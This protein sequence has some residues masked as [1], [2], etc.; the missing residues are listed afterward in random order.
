MSIQ[1][2]KI[3]DKFV[4][5]KKILIDFSDRHFKTQFFGREAFFFLLVE[6]L[7]IFDTAELTWNIPYMCFDRLL[8]NTN[9]YSNVNYKCWKWLILY[10]LEADAC[11]ANA[12]ITNSEHLMVPFYTGS[13]KRTRYFF[14]FSWSSRR[15]ISGNCMKIK[16]NR[17]FFNK[18]SVLRS[19][20]ERYEIFE[21]IV[22]ECHTVKR[23]FPGQQI[24][25]FSRN[26]AR[27]NEQ[28]SIVFTLRIFLGTRSCGKMRGNREIGLFYTKRLVDRFARRNESAFPRRSIPVPVS[29]KHIRNIV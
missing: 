29:I 1:L 4:I 11:K 2:P 24:S 5:Y 7:T 17:V 13:R 25:L 6:F 27:G 21:A 26:F 8:E 22:P 15:R 23:F 9:K 19:S 28:V 10:S 14:D 16:S 20:T 3:H 12:T 18:K